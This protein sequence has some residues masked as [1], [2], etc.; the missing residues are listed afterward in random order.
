MRMQ[1]RMLPSGLT[2]SALLGA[3]VCRRE[4]ANWQDLGSDCTGGGSGTAAQES[5]EPIPGLMVP[6][7]GQLP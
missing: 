1:G 4:G 3:P 2:Q 7:C 5:A 6:P